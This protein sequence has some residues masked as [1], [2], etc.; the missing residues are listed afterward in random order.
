MDDK[1]SRYNERFV[2][3]DHTERV[4][5][6]NNVKKKEISIDIPVLHLQW[7]A[8]ERTQVKQAWYMCN[9]LVRNSGDW[10]HINK[11][12]EHSLDND[13]IR[14]STVNQ[15]WF[16]GIN[17]EELKVITSTVYDY[18]KDWRYKELVMLFKTYGIEYFEKLNIWHIDKLNKAF[19]SKMKRKP[20][21]L[22]IDQPIRH[23]YYKACF[24]INMLLTNYNNVK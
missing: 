16:E 22:F 2:I 19:I 20:R 6:V 17:L 15:S 8:W 1:N 18:Q 9:E 10:Y 3:N 11:K 7:V 21:K 23:A 14:V 5:T 24:F 12:Y 13:H 4:P